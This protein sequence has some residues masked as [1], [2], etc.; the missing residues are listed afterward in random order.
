MFMTN[1]PRRKKYEKM[2]EYEDIMIDMQIL[3]LNQSNFENYKEKI[4]KRIP[5][6]TS[7]FKE[8]KT[9]IELFLKN[10]KFETSEKFETKVNQLLSN[11]KETEKYLSENPNLNHSF[12]TIIKI[13]TTKL[14]NEI[15]LKTIED[16]KILF[17][18]LDE[19]N[20]HIPIMLEIRRDKM[21]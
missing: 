11:L 7:I 20:S 21:K 4:N 17:A 3:L 13:L 9:L 12:K 5:E 16:G 10:E 2:L 8:V 1:I 15:S 6:L 18:N 19:F 14:N